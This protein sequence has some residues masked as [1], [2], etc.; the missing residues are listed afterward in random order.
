ML[1][2]CLLKDTEYLVSCNEEAVLD[3]QFNS[4]RLGAMLTQLGR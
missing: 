1:S 4:T 3:T 2:Q